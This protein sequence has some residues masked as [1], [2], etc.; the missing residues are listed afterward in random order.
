MRKCLVRGLMLGLTLLMLMAGGWLM[1][2]RAANADIEPLPQEAIRDSFKRSVVWLKTHDSK[3]LGDGN[4]ALWW[5]IAAAAER[6]GDPDLQALVKTSVDLVYAGQ[7]ARL[8]WRRL[9]E[10]KAVIEPKDSLLDGLV[11]Y[12]RFYYFS[13]TCQPVEPDQSGVG[14]RQ[15]IDDNMCRPM[16]SQV[17]LRDTVC[18]THQL[19]GIRMARHSGCALEPKVAKLEAEL[20][21]DI[22]WQLRVDPIFRDAYIQRVLTMY[23]VA[24]PQHVEPI[25]L[26]RVLQAQRAD[27]GWNGERFLL[28]LPD[29]LQPSTFRRWMSAIMPSRFPAGELESEFH[30]TAQGVLLMALAMNPPHAASARVSDR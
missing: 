2:A 10:P 9:V 20:I 21:D 17:L 12:Q 28:G 1:L 26:R 11:P 22:K 3:V 18:T 4:A 24:G 29:W 14:S 5:M 8:P 27:G 16:W 15:F 30:P 23:W 19:L 13:A 7:N 6:T 25:W